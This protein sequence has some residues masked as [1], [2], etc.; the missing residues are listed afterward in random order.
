MSCIKKNAIQEPLVDIVEGQAVVTDVCSIYE[1]DCHTIKVE[2]L[3]FISDFKIKCKR[4]DYVHAFVAFFDIV[5]SKCHKPVW[6]STGKLPIVSLYTFQEVFPVSQ[7]L[8]FFW[9]LILLIFLCCSLGPFAEYTHW[10]QTVFY[11]QDVFM[12]SRN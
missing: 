12:V 3:A 7:D 6:F 8:Y 9:K 2:E 1:I 5:F 10:K 11:L 4:N